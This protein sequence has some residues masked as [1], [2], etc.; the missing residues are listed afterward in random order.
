M[1]ARNAPFTDAELDRY[2]P[3][4]VLLMGETDL[5]AERLAR[6]PE[7]RA[8]FNV[9]GNFLAN[10]DY[11]YCQAHGIYF[12]TGGTAFAVP[13][14]EAALGMAIDLVRGIS[15][16]DREFRAGSETWFHEGT[17]ER[18]FLFTGA[19]VGIIGFGD[20]GR[21]LRR[22]LVPFRNP[23]TVYDPWVAPH[24]IEREDCRAA[25]LEDVLATSKAIFV[26][27]APTTDNAHFLGRAE[28]DRI[29]AGSAFVLMSRAGV[30]DFNELMR[31]VGAGRFAA[32]VDVFPEEPMPL[33]HP[34]RRLDGMLLSGHRTGGMT[35]AF[36]E[37]GRAHS[38]R[39]RA[40]ACR[41]ASPA[42]SSG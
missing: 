9:T 14:A 33:D 25:S 2:L 10:I 8:I 30:V 26:F 5:P 34:V 28:L 24:T 31:Q 32:A 42:L 11:D 35:E 41:P 20:L 13:V 4:A 1:V 16:H 21:A 12:L 3:R 40:V 39:R 23:V 7:L 18:T 29:P 36:H 22:M 27:A 17:R 19:P 6:A 37:I 15:R 38:R